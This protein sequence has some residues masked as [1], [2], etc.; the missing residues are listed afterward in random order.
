MVLGANGWESKKAVNYRKAV[1]ADRKSNAA[2]RFFEGIGG[3]CFRQQPNRKEE[4]ED[5]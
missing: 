2:E 5:R 4:D 1:K 3:G